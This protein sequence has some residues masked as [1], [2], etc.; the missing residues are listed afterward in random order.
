MNIMLWDRK[1]RGH[2]SKKKI[3]EGE[4][5]FLCG[6]K[7]LTQDVGKKGVGEAA[8]HRLQPLT[9][10]RHPL[11]V[12]FSKG[13]F[14]SQQEANLLPLERMLTAVTSVRTGGKEHKRKK[15]FPLQEKGKKTAPGHYQ[16]GSADLIKKAIRKGEN[17]V[18]MGFLGMANNRGWKEL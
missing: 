12:S 1:R 4:V 15:L 11:A 16:M 9:T 2:K 5:P 18:K 3:G 17:R 10:K 14:Q 7:W 13:S 8:G 6:K